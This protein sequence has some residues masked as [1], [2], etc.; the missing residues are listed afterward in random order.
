MEPVILIDHREDDALVFQIVHE[1][2]NCEVTR[3]PVGDYIVGDTI[4][5]RKSATDFVNSLKSGRLWDQA[6]KMSELEEYSKMFVV[7]GN[8]RKELFRRKVPRM[9]YYGTLAKLVR[10]F[11]ISVIELRYDTEFITFL[12]MLLKQI[13]KK[14]EKPTLK[15]KK[16]DNY[17][18]VAEDMLT[19][20]PGVGRKTAKSLMK[21]FGCLRRIAWANESDFVNVPGIGKKVAEKIFL[22]FNQGAR[23]E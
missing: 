18:D 3:L 21:H 1:V 11:N 16:Y 17:Y 19:I 4:I 10:S 14:T 22:T 9:S 7:I 23:R 5:E 2:G 8:I 15:R 6:L 13:T 12:K 20:I